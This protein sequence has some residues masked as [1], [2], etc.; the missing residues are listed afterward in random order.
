MTVPAVIE[1]WRPQAV[2]IHR[3]RRVS[4]PASQPPQP[5]QRKPSGQREANKYSRHASSVPKC[6]WNSRIVKG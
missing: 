2:Q 5:G 3:C 4:A 6:R 1:V